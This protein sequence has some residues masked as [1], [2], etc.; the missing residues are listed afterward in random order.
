MRL[1]HFSLPFL[2]ALLFLSLPAVE[3]RAQVRICAHRGF[4]DQPGG[5][6]TEN[7]LA[8]LRGAQ[9]NGFWG[10]EFD[11]HLT[12]DSLVV[13]H[14]DPWVADGST[15]IGPPMRTWRAF[16]W[17]MGRRSPPWTRTWTRG[18]APLACWWWNS[19]GRITASSPTK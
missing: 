16:R 19:N 9:E 4:W 17:P 6:T 5:A 13:V 3:S 18:W 2:L 1:H 12:A 8:S 11:L 15:S 14:H 7:S 10:S